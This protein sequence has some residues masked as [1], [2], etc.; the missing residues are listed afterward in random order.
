[1]CCCEAFDLNLYQ[2]YM[3]PT[4]ESHQNSHAHLTR[5]RRQ[6]HPVGQPGHA[7]NAMDHQFGLN[8]CVAFVAAYRIYRSY[9]PLF[10]SFEVFIVTPPLISQEY[11]FRVN[12]RYMFLSS[13]CTIYNSSSICFFHFIFFHNKLMKIVL[14]NLPLLLFHSLNYHHLWYNIMGNG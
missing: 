7:W 5:L 3:I 10:S 13:L 2:I 11:Q 6:H 12:L 4:T 9:F 8:H 14:Y 1:M